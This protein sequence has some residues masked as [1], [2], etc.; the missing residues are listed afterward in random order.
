MSHHAK[1][2]QLVA[3]IAINIAMSGLTFVVAQYFFQQGGRT[4]DLGRRAC[5]TWCCPVRGSGKHPLHRLAVCPPDRRPFGAGVLAFALVPLVHWVVY[6]S[7]FGL[8]LRACGENPHAADAP[9]S[10]S[11]ASATWP[12]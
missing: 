12:C 9:A 3:G 8:R 10:A 4:P 5:S 2:N 11:N 7:R 6:H 1:G